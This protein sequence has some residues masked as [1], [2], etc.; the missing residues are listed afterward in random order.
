LFLKATDEL[1]VDVAVKQ[2]VGARG[3]FAHTEVER[4]FGTVA[5]P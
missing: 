1:H 4:E 5:R 3:L 2:D